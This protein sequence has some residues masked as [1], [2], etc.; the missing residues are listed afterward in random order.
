MKNDE[1][2]EEFFADSSFD[3]SSERVL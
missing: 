3:F 2:I 1:T